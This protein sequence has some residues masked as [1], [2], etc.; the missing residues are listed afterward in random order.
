MHLQFGP[1]S[2][3]EDLLSRVFRLPPPPALLVAYPS[4]AKTKHFS[5]KM[6]CFRM[7][8][9]HLQFGPPIRALSHLGLVP[10]HQDQFIPQPQ[11]FSQ[12]PNPFTL[13]TFLYDK[14]V[15]KP[16]LPFALT[17]IDW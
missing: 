11:D 12:S 4:A 14:T 8:G 5:E 1:P 15:E 16:F 17:L 2:P 3:Q 7:R 13:N 6:L 10:Q 9:V